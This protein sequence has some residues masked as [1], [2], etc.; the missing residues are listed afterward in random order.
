MK[1]IDVKGTVRTF[2]VRTVTHGKSSAASLALDQP[3]KAFETIITVRAFGNWLSGL[4]FVRCARS[5][6][7]SGQEFC[8]SE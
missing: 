7:S 8:R 4:F 2:G 5:R 1:G 3:A 6:L